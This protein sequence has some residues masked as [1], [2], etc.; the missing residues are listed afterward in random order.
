MEN[1]IGAL[2]IDRLVFCQRVNFQFSKRISF[3][4]SGNE[5]AALDLR[6]AAIRGTG[7]LPFYTPHFLAVR[8]QPSGDVVPGLTHIFSGTAQAV[9]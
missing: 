5:Q 6:A 7:I 4:V 9:R 3:C 8:R 1:D 2:K